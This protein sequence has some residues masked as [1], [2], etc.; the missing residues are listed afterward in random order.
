MNS[1]ERAIVRE[2]LTTVDAIARSATRRIDQ[3]VGRIEKQG[4]LVLYA[5]TELREIRD[6]LG[7]IEHRERPL[8]DLIN[9]QGKRERQEREM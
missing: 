3:L 7:D 5:P 1:S 4:V 9:E 6:M 2:T 8:M